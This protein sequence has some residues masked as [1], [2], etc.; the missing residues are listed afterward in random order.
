MFGQKVS[1]R[2]FANSIEGKRFRNCF[3]ERKRIMYVEIVSQR[4]CTSLYL[5]LKLEFIEMERSLDY[6]IVC[7]ST[8]FDVSGGREIAWTLQEARRSRYIDRTRIYQL[9]M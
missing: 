6:Q 7:D 5:P 3:S 1:V 9:A 2:G 4:P 8:M